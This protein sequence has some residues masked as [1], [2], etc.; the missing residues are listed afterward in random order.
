MMDDE[1]TPPVDRVMESDPVHPRTH[2][3]LPDRRRGRH[4]E[5][6]RRDTPGSFEEL[7]EAAERSHQILEKSGSPYRFCVYREGGDVFIDLVVLD[8]AGRVKQNLKQKMDP[9]RF[10]TW[11]ARLE[12][13]GGLMVDEE[14]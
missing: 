3:E 5:E 8:A 13:G 9:D 1:L 11:V 2:S 14:A 12:A 6:E 7:L 4:K 10:Y